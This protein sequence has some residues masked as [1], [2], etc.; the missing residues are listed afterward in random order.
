MEL[1][2]HE[3]FGA[4]TYGP[5]V[6][7]KV[8]PSS[9]IDLNTCCATTSRACGSTQVSSRVAVLARPPGHAGPCAIAAPGAVTH[10]TMRSERG[11]LMWIS[12]IIGRTSRIRIAVSRPIFAQKK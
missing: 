4:V 1:V 7:A 5:V 12:A 2:G 8:Y 9:V 3:N 6:S 11:I 10:M